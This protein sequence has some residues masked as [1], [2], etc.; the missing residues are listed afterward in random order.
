MGHD[1]RS[2]PKRVGSD[3]PRA[4]E[5]QSDSV[6]L[7]SVSRILQYEWAD[8]LVSSP[9][10]TPDTNWVPG[11]VG[12]QWGRVAPD[13]W[14][15]IRERGYDPHFKHYPTRDRFERG[16]LQFELWFEGISA[17]HDFAETTVAR[18]AATVRDQIDDYVTETSDVGSWERAEAVSDESPV[19]WRTTYR[20]PPEDDVAYSEALRRAIEDHEWVLGLVLDAVDSSN[21]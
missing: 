20:Y 7:G 19:V 6:D 1:E 12:Q 4:I 15:S 17:D 9:P 21:R 18:V 5:A 11:H 2:G 14:R 13:V 16:E 8:V 3:A 10:M